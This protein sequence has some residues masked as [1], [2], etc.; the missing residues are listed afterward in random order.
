MKTI[1][2]LTWWIILLAALN[3]ILEILNII[4]TKEWRSRK[5]NDADLWIRGIFYYNPYDKRIVLPKK[6]R[7]GLTYNFAH[8]ISIFVTSIII[9]TTLF[10]IY[11][12]IFKYFL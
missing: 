11:Y 2:Y 1:Y 8:P 3:I 7:L 4:K 12:S 6:N 10:N 9:L 5:I